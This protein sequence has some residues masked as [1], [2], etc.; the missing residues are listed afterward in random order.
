MT[1]I[2]QKSFYQTVYESLTDEYWYTSH[3]AK[4]TQTLSSPIQLIR[5]RTGD[6]VPFYRDKINRCLSA[7]G[8]FSAYQTNVSG[9]PTVSNLTCFWDGI[10]KQWGHFYASSTQD[11]EYAQSRC[12]QIPVT[13]TTSVVSEAKQKFI[14]RANKHLTSFGGSEFVGELKETLQ[15][16]W[17]PA[18]TFREG[19]MHYLKVVPKKVN[20]VRKPDITKVLSDTWLEYSFGWTPLIGDAKQACEAYNR[21]KQRDIEGKFI[22][23]HAQSLGFGSQTES[24]SVQNRA[25]F[26]KI[27][28]RTSSAECRIHGVVKATQSGFATP[29]MRLFGFSLDRF[30]PTVWELI[31]YSWLVDYFVNVNSVLEAVSFLSANLRWASQTTVQ[32]QKC[33]LYNRFNEATTRTNLGRYKLISSETTE[34]Q[35]S[36]EAKQVL[37][38]NVVSWVPEIAFRLPS[39]GHQVINIDAIALQHNASRRNITRR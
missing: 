37:R 15:M 38:Q 5:S 33:V 11:L 28:T 16:L 31:P 36:C 4:P 23:A 30:V 3:P 29:E 1:T 14:S 12:T 27:D 25:Y 2:T 39:H 19:L 17:N 24:D 8:G 10:A 32:R 20:R 18:R 21:L 26:R 7:T 22:S 9:S 6:P 34:G 35:A 13:S